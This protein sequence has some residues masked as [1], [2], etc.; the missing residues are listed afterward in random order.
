MTI[1]SVTQTDEFLNFLNTSIETT[2]FR[3]KYLL[4]ILDLAFGKAEAE[5][6]E[7]TA[8]YQ[9]EDDWI[10]YIETAGQLF[11]YGSDNDE[12]LTELSNKINLNAFHGFEI[13][14]EYNLVYKLLDKQNIHDYSVI[15]DRIFYRLANTDQLLDILE[16]TSADMDDAEELTQMMLDYYHEEY[17]GTRDKQYDP[18]FNGICQF[19]MTQ[20]IHI[21]KE[22]NI[23]KAFCTIIDPDIGIIYTKPEFRK[24]QIG[25][26][27][28]STCSHIL[29]ELNDES[30][31]MTDLN[32]PASNKMTQDIGYEEIYRHSNIKI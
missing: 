29:M 19:I 5:V 23:V 20:T 8:V 3:Y 15:K 1:I 14:G 4:G 21:F 7:N 18:I 6:T 24:N 27:L 30:Y 10:I 25:K 13:M 17:N 11:L 9:S 32:S 12:L 22:N 26:K 16:N 28:L 31:L 2:D